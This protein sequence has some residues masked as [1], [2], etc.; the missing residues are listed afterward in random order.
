MLMAF[1]PPAASVPPMTVATISQTEGQPAFGDDHRRDRRDEE[2][3][4]DARLRQRDERPD[5]RAG[6]DPTFAVTQT[7]RR[8]ATEREGGWRGP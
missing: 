7:R 3:L 5:P 8:A 6:G 1:A 4:D 2:Q